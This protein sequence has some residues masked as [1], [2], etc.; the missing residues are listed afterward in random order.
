MNPVLILAHNNLALTQRTV[1]SVQAQ[2]IPTELFVIDNDSTDGTTKWLQ[3]RENHATFRPQLGVSAGWN[4]GLQHLFRLHEHVL[5]INNDVVLPYWFYR[6]L[7]GYEV[8]FVT[9]VAVD[10][11][12]TEP[13]ERMPLTPNPDFSAFLIHKAAWETIGQFNVDMKYYSSDQDYHVRGWLAG[14]PMM[15]ANVPYYHERSSTLKLAEPSE[16]EAIQRQADADRE[17][18]RLKWGVVSGSPDYEA[19]FKPENFGRGSF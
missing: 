13:A 18:F 12:P 15:K 10:K 6:F 7:L 14:V 4:Y 17:M 2:D 16:R 19:I 3:A 9:G 1:A 11:M 8:P 5:V